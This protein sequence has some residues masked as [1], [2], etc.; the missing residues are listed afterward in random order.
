MFYLLCN[1]GGKKMTP[2]IKLIK[3]YLL[4]HNTVQFYK[5]A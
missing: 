5:I 4:L 2:V 1:T 3:L